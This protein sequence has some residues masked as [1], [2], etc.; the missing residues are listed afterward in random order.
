[1]AFSGES[2]YHKGPNG[3]WILSEAGREIVV[4]DENTQCI[5]L[6]AKLAELR[7]PLARYLRAVVPK[8]LALSHVPVL[9]ASAFS[10]HGRL[11]AISGRSGAGKTTTALAFQKAGASLLSEDLLVLRVL[12]HKVAVYEDGEQLARQ[13]ANTTAQ[14]LA[15]DPTAAVHYV[16]LKA[17][18]Q[19]ELLPLESIWFIAAERRS[20]LQISLRPLAATD[21]TVALLGSGFLASS[22]AD[23]WREFVRRGA[24]IAQR[25]GAA[26]A[27]TPNGLPELEAAAKL[28]IVN[29]AS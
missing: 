18:E 8:L 2:L 4:I 22:A 16:S 19:G 3:T 5:E 9:H 15:N 7:A 14:T 20:G 24:E 26:E 21:R 17:V 25:V 28:Y 13:W 10:V 6:R 11:T 29:S 27:I 23:H 12:D 1:M